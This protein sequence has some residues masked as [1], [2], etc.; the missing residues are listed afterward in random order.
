VA[1]TWNPWTSVADG[2]TQPGAPVNVAGDTLLASDTTGATYACPPRNYND[3]AGWQWVS[4]GRAIP[5]APVTGAFN[6][7]NGVNTTTIAL[8]DPLGG[9]FACD[10]IPDGDTYTWSGWD[11]V[12]NITVPPGSAVNAYPNF[13][14]GKTDLYVTDSNGVVSTASGAPYKG[15]SEW[16][17]PS[18]GGARPGSPVTMIMYQDLPNIFTAD[19]GGYIYTTFKDSY[20]YWVGWASVSQGQAV[21]GA[22]VA[23]VLL[24]ERTSNPPFWTPGTIFLIIADSLGGIFA[25]SGVPGNW[26]PW[27]T[28]AGG[29]TIPG[30]KITPLVYLD[31]S[32]NPVLALF[33]TNENGSV[34]MTTR[35]PQTGWNTWTLVSDESIFAPPGAPVSAIL[36]SSTQLAI[37]V[38]DIEG[39]V[40]TAASYSIT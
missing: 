26:G 25:T 20:G 5:G 22:P 10:T 1:I 17:S 37:F 8:V 14:T 4:Q 40:K 7:P 38:A 31:P 34:Q 9:V 36:W 11:S 15:W 12:P 39:N 29:R 23:A 33:C 3:W 27:K 19:T 35:D 18:Q 13:A 32:G 28:V 21:P 16:L 24:Q 30:A 6:T 2:K